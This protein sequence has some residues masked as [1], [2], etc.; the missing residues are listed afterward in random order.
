MKRLIRIILPGALL[1][2]F[3]CSGCSS[4]GYWGVNGDLPG[5]GASYYMGAGYPGRHYS[6]KQYK[7][8]RKEQ[9]KREK[10]RRKAMKKARK[11]AQKH[12]KCH[13][14]HHDD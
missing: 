11:H 5:A 4:G 10:E 9:R 12:H 3:I 2:T 6:E 8:M 14:G 13:H 1:L 7:K